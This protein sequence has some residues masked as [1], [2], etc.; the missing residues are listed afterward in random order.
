MRFLLVFH[1]LFLS[2]FTFSQ[3]WNLIWNDEFN[4]TNLDLNKWSHDIGTGSQNGMMGWGNNERQYYKQGNS[5]VSNGTLKIIAKEEQQGIVDSWNNTYYYSSSRITTKDNF[6]FRYGKIVARI[7]T[8]DGKGFWPAFWML[9][10]NLNWPCDGEIDIMEQW[11]SNGLTNVTTG[12][13]HVG[14][15]PYSSSTHQYQ[16]FSHQL[17]SGSF[18]DAFHNYEVIWR[19]NK[20]EWYVDGV[21]FFDVSPNLFNQQYNWPFNSK[22]WFLIL[23]LAITSSGPTSSTVFPNSIEVDYV[24]VYEEIGNVAGC[25]D[26]T[27]INYY[28]SATFN[29]NSCEYNVTFRLDMN[30][31]S[32]NFTQPEVNGSFNNWCGSCAQMQDPDGDN[33]WQ[34]TIKLSQGNYKYKYSVDNWADSENLTSNLTCIL[35]AN[36]YTN[37]ILNLSSDT[38]LD[39]VCWEKC[40]IKSCKFNN[41]F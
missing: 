8:L 34:K 21:K 13:A 4:G 20:I 38:I 1:I 9:P 23:N 7:K 30:N 40:K 12:A 27:A 39:I 35:T 29:D 25:T 2:N 17:N 10:L 16:S 19:P 32:N 28:P 24:R 11:G 18:A 26:S 3:N 14:L 37:R 33:I 15:C 6:N 5:I 22:N 36:G 41:G 31:Y